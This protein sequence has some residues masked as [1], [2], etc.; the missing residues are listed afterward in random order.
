MPKILVADK[1]SSAGPEILKEAG[2]EADVKTGLSEDELV[3]TIGEYEGL[4]VRSATKVSR[5]VI[6]AAEKLRVIGRAGVGVDNIDTGAATERGIVVMNTPL[7][8]IVSAAEQAVA[9]M[10]SLA[11]STPAADAS[12]KQGRW[13]KKAFTG[14]ELAGKTLGIVGLGKIGAI[15]ARVGKALSMRVLA[16]DPY[17][18]PDR[19]ADLDC[20][21]VDLD[22][23]LREADF[24]T[25]HVPL[26]DS[27]RGLIGTDELRKMKPTARLVNC[28]RGG[29]VDEDA[30]SEALAG[31]EIAGAALDVYAREPL[32]EE[33]PLRKAPNIVLTPHLGASTAEAQEKVAADLAKQFVDYFVR[34]EIKNPVNLSVTLKPHLT[35]F[36]GLAETLGRFVSQIAP[37]GLSRVEVGV[38][39]E[40]G[41]SADDT[42]VLAVC[43]LQGVLGDRV[44]EN[45]NVVNV[46]LIAKSRGIELNV[47]RAD[48]ARTYR[49]LIVVKLLADGKG[50]S[51]AGTLFEG[52][53]ARI[54]AIDDFDIDVRPAPW[55]L[56]MSYPDR[57]GMIGKIGTILGEAGINIAGMSVGRREKRGQAFVV[58]T[59]DEPVSAGVAERIR[60]AIDAEVSR[61]RIDR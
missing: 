8:N 21:Q 9:L 23:L 24:V 61:I 10:F 27:T 14:V 19:A 42:Q 38:Y 34:G 11:R 5:R 20:E 35:A 37:G 31:G 51:V 43:A 15:V 26:N 49:N 17:L 57:P 44:D 59:V 2:L 53:G 33:S 25:L 60:S 29:V 56:A 13:E 7:G 1:M 47:R 40:L 22:A 30:L 39:G 46:G 54:V 3:D 41:R 58:L 18:N 16:F 48:T 4:M 6:E 32:A 52:T 12:M 45:V 28:A 50:R 55:M 36:A